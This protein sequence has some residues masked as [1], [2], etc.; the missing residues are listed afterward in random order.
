M[1]RHLELIYLRVLK[2]Q[3]HVVF[4]ALISHH[5]KF[6]ALYK[7]ILIAQNWRIKSS[8]NWRIKSCKNW[9]IKSSK[10]FALKTRLFICLPL[11]VEKNIVKHRLIPGEV[12]SPNQRCWHRD[13]C[14]RGFNKDKDLLSKSILV[15]RQVKGCGK[16]L[17]S[18]T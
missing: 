13:N 10:N 4:I 9:R 17:C 11:T 16:K 7:S 6:T 14:L 2:N 5:G 12:V 15:T 8:K 1:W 3:L 18:I